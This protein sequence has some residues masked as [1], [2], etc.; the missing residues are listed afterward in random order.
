MSADSY[1]EYFLILLG[2]ILNNA[3]WKT[4]LSTGLFALPIA[5]K[6]VATWLR[7]REEGDDEG[8]KGTLALV[9]IEHVIYVAFVVL[10]F[11]VTPV[12]NVDVNTIKF[13]K[14]RSAQCGVNIPLPQKSGYA[15]LINDFDGK[16]AM[17]PVWW[18]MIHSLSKGVTH[19]TI[20][21][22]PCG[23][24]LRQLRFDVQH[25]QIKDPILLEEVQDFANQ[26]YAKAYF[27]LK[28]TNAQLSDA[29]INSVGW[30]GSDYFLST[31]GYYD[32]YTSTKPR[33]QWPY[34]ANR[35]DGY[36]GVGRGGYPTCKQWWNTPTVGLKTRVMSSYNDIT[37]RALKKKFG[38]EWE[39]IALRWVVSPKNASLSGDGETY[40]MGNN[41]SAGTFSFVSS[42]LG[43]LG[44]AA[45]QVVALPGFD[46][47]KYTLPMV[48]A[49]LEMALVIV[50]P[51]VLM[52]SVYSPKAVVTVSFA[53]F[54]LMFLTFWWEFAG[55]LDD[56]LIDIVY[57]GLDNVDG[58]NPVPFA[59]FA[60]S[61]TDGWVMNLVMGTMYLV[62]PAFWIGALSWAGIKVGGEVAGSLQKGAGKAQSAG[63]KGGEV[64]SD[65]AGAAMTKGKSMMK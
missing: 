21:G 28:S 2:W 45:G 32:Y 3:I 8:N 20:A 49:L 12:V 53:M 34:D 65:V 44:V 64:A 48:Q 9:R 61:T 14:E 57:S 62:F 40:M 59:D 43:S 63:E 22:I 24:N 5:G 29:T 37:T 16:T 35:D 10:M 18:Y 6:V 39:E 25:T 52:F 11:C 31:S 13:N 19:A 33:S 26:C 47:L 17:V 50:I 58:G 27:R 4:L 60:G 41:A 7:T 30:I 42:A 15:T 51:L 23:D 36:P 1:L 54:A 56:R 38:N 46:I 55:W